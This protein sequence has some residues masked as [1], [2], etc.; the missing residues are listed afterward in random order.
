[1]HDVSLASNLLERLSIMDSSQRILITVDETAKRLSCGITMVYALIN[2]NSFR[3][4]KLGK[5]RLIDVE[6]LNRFT[7]SLTNQSGK[8]KQ[9]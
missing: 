5:K 8:A 3:S 9:A 6:S 7:A 4:V 1:M 2:R